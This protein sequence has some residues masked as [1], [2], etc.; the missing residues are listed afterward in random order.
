MAEDSTLWSTPSSRRFDRCRLRGFARFGARSSNP[1]RRRLSDPISCA[2]A[3]PTEIQEKAYGGLDPATARLLNQL[4]ALH[5]KTPGKIV[6]PRRMKPGVILVRE[7][8]GDSHRVTVL[9]D[10]FAYEGKTFDSLSEI[11]RLITGTRWN[12]PRFFG[13]RSGNKE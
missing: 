1:S 7:W 6:L 13:L 12:G 8:K 2:A 3:S 5:A 10:G 4:I 11:A 9:Q